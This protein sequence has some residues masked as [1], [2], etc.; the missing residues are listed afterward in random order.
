MRYLRIFTI[1]FFLGACSLFGWTLHV[2]SQ[3][4][5]ANPEIS[6]SI[7]EL[8]LQVSE[9][10]S[11]LLKGLTASDNKDGDLTEQIMVERH[12]RF[13]EPGVCNV[14]YV[15]FDHSSNFCRYERTVIYD[16]YQ[17]PRLH[18]DMP[19]LY[20][21]GETIFLLDRF[22]LYDCIDGDIT[23]KLKLESSN[24]ADGEEGIY[25]IELRA[26]NNYGDNVYAKVPINI[27]DYS[28]N[29]PLI[30]L[31]QY[32]V[33]TKVGQAVDPLTYVKSVVNSEGAPMSVSDIRFISQVDLSKSGGGQIRLEVTDDKGI[34]GVTYLTVIVE[35]I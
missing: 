21:T 31:T 17:P 16:D 27:A 33:Y 28:A 6:D 15:V 2:V 34:T 8:H 7:G 1:V 12:S 4:D 9:D 24:V 19:L 30:T 20:R 10:P 29:A 14:S 25:E 35:E 18:L 5:T 26:T 22:R 32:L 11:S 3:Q 23:H 13:I